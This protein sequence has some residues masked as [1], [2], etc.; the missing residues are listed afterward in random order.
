MVEST[1]LLVGNYSNTTGYAWSNIYRLYNE[2][3]ICMQKKG[4]GVCLSFARIESPVELI[5]KDVIYSSF[6]FDPINVSLKG[7]Y[8]IAKAIRKYRIKY[9]YFTDQRSVRGLYILLRILGVKRIIVHCRVSVADPSPAQ[10]EI[11]F[12]WLAKTV[13]SAIGWITPDKIY[14]VSDFVRNRLIHKNCFPIKKTVTIMNGIDIE[15]YRCDA[16]MLIPKTLR[17]FTGARANAYKG[18]IVLIYAANLLIR[19]HKIRNFVIHYAGDGPDL[20]KFMFEVKRLNL[21]QKFIFLGELEETR[22]AVCKADIVVV[23]SAW[24]DACPSSVSEAMAAG[25]PLITTFAGGIPEIVGDVSNAILVPPSDEHALAN[26]L[27][28]LITD[29]EKR[30]RLGINAR[31]RAVSALDEKA[32]YRATINQL[33]S[34]IS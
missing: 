18:I 11:G 13:I 23:P 17:I 29:S 9:I 33:I 7:L 1:L 25:K 20:D 12:W 28:E 21:Q 32:Y 16:T 31:A 14:A 22:D 26:E 30:K 2:I 4:V 6:E 24:G 8:A 34:D 5:D 27:A 3:A 15:H 19:E 10:P